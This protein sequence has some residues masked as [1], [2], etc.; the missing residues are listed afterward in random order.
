[1]REILKSKSFTAFLLLLS[2]FIVYTVFLVIFIQPVTAIDIN[3]IL[4]IKRFFEFLPL[5]L[6]VAI[7][8]FG[9]TSYFIQFL[10][11]LF[12]ICIYLKKYI[13]FILIT[14]GYLLVVPFTR[15]VKNIIMR[16]RPDVHL[17][18]VAETEFSYPSG[19]S[20]TAFFWGV[21]LLYLIKTYVKNNTAKRILF[22]VIILWM[23]TVPFTRVWLGVHFPTD[24]LGGALL[25]SSLSCFVITLV[26]YFD[27][28]KH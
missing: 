19:H 16:D 8:D 12:I 3:A 13:T 6:V 27:N 28:K 18:R 26:D 10:I 5:G 25:G 7:T 2:G 11:P 17:Q 21:I 22:G 4:A 14:A 24:T 20:L 1:M 23:L 15:V 9:I